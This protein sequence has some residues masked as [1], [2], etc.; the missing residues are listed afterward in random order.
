MTSGMVT[1]ASETASIGAAQLNASGVATLTTTLLPVGSDSITASF[2]ASADDAASTSSAATVTVSAPVTPS[3]TIT[4]NPDSLSI[5]AG[6][7]GS[8]TLTFTP[9][10]GYA[11]R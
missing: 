6:L 4:A 5:M 2:A 9:T 7:T 3:Y 8:T 11:A 10:G 1:F